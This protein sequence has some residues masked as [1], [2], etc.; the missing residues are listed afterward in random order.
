MET[1]QEHVLYVFVILC[2]IGF[3]FCGLFLVAAYIAH[4]AQERDRKKGLR[5]KFEWYL[6]GRHIDWIQQKIGA[7]TC[8]FAGHKPW[9]IFMWSMSGPGE[10]YFYGGCKRCGAMSHI[11]HPIPMSDAELLHWLQIHYPDC[12]VIHLGSH[13]WPGRIKAGEGVIVTSGRGKILQ[14]DEK[15]GYGKMECFYYELRPKKESEHGA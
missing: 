2:V 5:G 3:A 4:K 9:K 6:Y 14:W 15:D 11:E 8:F 7:F 13:P 10:G 12:Y 1:P